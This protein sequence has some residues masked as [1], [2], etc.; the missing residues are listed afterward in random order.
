MGRVAFPFHR[1]TLL[2]AA[3]QP[4]ATVSTVAYQSKKQLEANKR[5]TLSR[6]ISLHPDLSSLQLNSPF[7]ATLM[8][9]STVSTSTAQDFLLALCSELQTV[10]SFNLPDYWSRWME[11][12]WPGCLLSKSLKIRMAS[13]CSNKQANLGV[14]LPK[15]CRSE[16][17]P[18]NWIQFFL[19][20]HFWGLDTIWQKLSPSPARLGFTTYFLFLSHIMT[21]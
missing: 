19:F 1:I 9:Q 13:K 3:I 18:K 20:W 17:W 10:T 7:R 16:R 11:S 14:A 2:R 5:G 21:Q 8:T 15:I 12:V 4:K 6:L